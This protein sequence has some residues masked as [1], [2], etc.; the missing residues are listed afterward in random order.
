[1]LLHNRWPKFFAEYRVHAGWFLLFNRRDGI[2]DFF[3]RVFDGT[4]CTRSF[5]ARS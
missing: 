4:L 1:V 3:V 2:L 5:A